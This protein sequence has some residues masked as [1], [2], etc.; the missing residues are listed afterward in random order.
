[1]RLHFSL[2]PLAL[3]MVGAMLSAEQRPELS[4]NARLAQIGP[5]TAVTTSD[6]NLPARSGNASVPRMFRLTGQLPPSP[7]RS[8]AQPTTRLVTFALYAQQEGGEPIWSETQVV[9][10]DV[11]GQYT[12]TLG[13]TALAGIPADVFSSGDARWLSITVEGEPQQPRLLLVSVPY[14]LK[15]EEAEKLG[16]KAASEFVTK[17]DLQQAVQQAATSAVQSQIN[18]RQSA[19]PGSGKVQPGGLDDTRQASLS[20]ANGTFITQQGMTSGGAASFSDTSGGE[21]V[22]VNQSG[23]GMGL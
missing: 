11:T 3:L 15:A 1:M 20:T 6:T 23:T 19:Q 8:I 22:V 18:S 17:S 14:A 12:V 16:G 9:T 10:L 21:V 4:R 7:G 13:S 5:E 2:L